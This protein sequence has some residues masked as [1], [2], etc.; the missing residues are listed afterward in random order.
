[1]SWV[2]WWVWRR[3]AGGGYGCC[4]SGGSEVGGTAVIGVWWVW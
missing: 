3:E 2:M 4:G 1:M